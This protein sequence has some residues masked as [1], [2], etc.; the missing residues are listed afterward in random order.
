[1]K[2]PTLLFRWKK[3]GET[4]AWHTVVWSGYSVDK[5]FVAEKHLIKAM[6]ERDLIKLNYKAD[7]DVENYAQSIYEE[8]EGKTDGQRN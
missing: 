3:G 1:M 6:K 4:V 8:L 2:I 7:H 5:D